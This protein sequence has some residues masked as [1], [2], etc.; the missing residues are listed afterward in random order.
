[1]ETLASGPAI[2]AEGGR[3]MRMGLAPALHEMV[4]GNVDRVTTREMANAAESDPAIREAI[5]NAATFIGIAAANVIAILHPDMIVLGGGVAELGEVL[6]Q[7]VSEV[8]A[9]RVKMFPTDHIQ[10]VPSKLGER[11]GVMG[12]IAL[13]GTATP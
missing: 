11:A 10:V 8:I 9:D 1:L 2:A 12:A 5:E 3:L 13:A 4:D 6:V 7:T